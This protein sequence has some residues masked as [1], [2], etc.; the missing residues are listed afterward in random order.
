M[1]PHLQDKCLRFRKRIGLVVS[2]PSCT[3]SATHR[4]LRLVNISHVLSY[5]IGADL[6]VGLVLSFQIFIFYYQNFYNLL[7]CPLKF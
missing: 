6:H 1:I 3:N 7:F 5:T 4:L 2:A